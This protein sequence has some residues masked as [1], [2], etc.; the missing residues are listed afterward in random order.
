M[1]ACGVSPKQSFS[2][3]FPAPCFVLSAK[4]R[5][6]IYGE[7][8]RNETKRNLSKSA[9]NFKGRLQE[10]FGL[11]CLPCWMSNI[12]AACS[13]PCCITQNMLLFMSML[14]SHVYATC[15]CQCCMSMYMLRV[16]VHAA[17]PWLCCMSML[18]VHVNTACPCPCCI[19]MSMLYVHAARTWTCSMNLNM[20]HWHGQATWTENAAFDMYCTCCMDMSV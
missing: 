11:P 15:S 6:N 13:S 12:Y 10:I 16:Y 18:Y 20:Q 5:R 7:K 9:N 17:Y 14:H 2:F 8:K 19:S 4:F 3:R 1:V